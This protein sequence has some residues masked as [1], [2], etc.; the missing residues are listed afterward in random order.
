MASINYTNQPGAGIKFTIKNADSI[1]KYLSQLK[2]VFTMQ[3]SSRI[4][5]AGAKAFKSH[6]YQDFVTPYRVPRSANRDGSPYTP[7][8]RSKMAETIT[9]QK[10]RGTYAYGVGFSEAGR[11]AYLARFLNDGWDPRNQYGGPYQHV[12]GERF[13]ERAE[14][15]SKEDV[16]E[17]MTQA[18][19]LVLSQIFGHGGVITDFET[20]DGVDEETA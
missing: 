3:Q 15:D 14:I 16:D 4:T 17:A 1:E 12:E 5:R 9:I 20:D 8:D 7:K 2:S 11:K 18:A 19:N 13:F 6:L 10:Q